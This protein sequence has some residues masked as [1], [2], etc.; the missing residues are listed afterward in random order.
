[1]AAAGVAAGIPAAAER[2]G[3]DF[4]NGRRLG[5][6]KGRFETKRIPMFNSS[7]LS[8]EQKARIRQ[9]VDEGATMADIQ[10]RLGEELGVSVTYMETRFVILDLGLTLKE[11]PKK[12]EPQ[13]QALAPEAADD[14]P[15]VPGGVGVTVDEVAVPGAVASGKATF[16]DGQRALWYLDQMGRLG[17]DPDVAGYRPTREDVAEF[18]RQ[19]SLLLGK[20][21]Y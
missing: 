9:W 7:K 19:L 15:N 17:L 18:Q 13:P 11:A 20:R 21:G 14:V 10:R 12:E 4:P 2:S 5:L 6:A 16:S 8:D 1:M 3:G